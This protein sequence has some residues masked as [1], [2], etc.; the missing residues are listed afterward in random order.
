MR[1]VC[2][3]GTWDHRHELHCETWRARED[4]D[5]L[6]PAALRGDDPWPVDG[7]DESPF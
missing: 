2:D 3:C 4:P 5:W 7:V 6:K 1:P